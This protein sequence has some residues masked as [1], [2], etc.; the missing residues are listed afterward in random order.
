M[1]LNK[2]TPHEFYL[3]TNGGSGWNRHIIGSAIR[4]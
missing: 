1:L 2:I 3:E 4:K